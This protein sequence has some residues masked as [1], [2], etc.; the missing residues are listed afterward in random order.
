MVRPGLPSDRLVTWEFWE[1]GEGWEVWV[2]R[3]CEWCSLSFAESKSR[4]W[5]VSD[6]VTPC[7]ALRSL[8]LPSQPCS[9]SFFHSHSAL[10]ASTSPRMHAFCA[11]PH[12][13]TTRLDTPHATTLQSHSSP[14]QP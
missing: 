3:L 6:P 2:R 7:A 5:C 14:E 12:A 13:N 1:L 9:V 4:L 8:Y 10:D 11:R